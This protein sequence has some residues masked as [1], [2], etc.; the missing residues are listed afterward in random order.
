MTLLKTM[1]SE[2]VCFSLFCI[3]IPSE[4]QNYCSFVSIH[5][6]SGVAVFIFYRQ[7]FKKNV[8][9]FEL[10][11]LLMFCI[12]IKMLYKVS[13]VYFQLSHLFMHFTPVFYF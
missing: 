5:L 8:H 3:A 13:S 2:L 12:I 11:L 9:L 6:V 7:T 4:L 1:T 10:P